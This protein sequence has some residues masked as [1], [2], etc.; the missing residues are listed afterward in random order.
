MAGFLFTIVEG[1]LQLL[2]IAILAS[3]I[4]SWL[5]AFNVINMRNQLV[6]NVARFLDAVT[7]PV[8]RPAQRLIPPLG[9]VDVSPILVILVLQAAHNYLVPWL[10]RPLFNIIG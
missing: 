5:I 9:G 7:A 8:L 3:A 2:I 6:Y 10:F 1:I 4:M